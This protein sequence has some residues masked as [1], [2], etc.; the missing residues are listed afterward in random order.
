M[1]NFQELQEFSHKNANTFSYG[2]RIL[3]AKQL[4]ETIEF[5]YSPVSRM[6]GTFKE[7][8]FNVAKLCQEKANL[9]NRTPAVMLSGGMDSHVV[10]SSFVEQGLECVPVMSLIKLNGRNL[11]EH[12]QFYAEK[13]CNYF[14]LK[15]EK[16]DVNLEW[17]SSNEA[18]SIYSNVGAFGI[19]RLV[20][21]KADTFAWN[22]LNGMAVYGNGD[23]V[24][25]NK[26]QTWCLRQL[27]QYQV[28]FKCG[29]L[30]NKVNVSI[31]F[32]HTPEILASFLNEGIIKMVTKLKS[33]EE[34]TEFRFV[35]Y[36]VYRKHWP[37]LEMRPKFS[38]MEKCKIFFDKAREDF[39]SRLN[40]IYD[41]FW[42]KP[43][44]Q[45]NKIL[46]P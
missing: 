41:D 29:L 34:F 13:I 39:C 37:F 27:G 42:Y 33:P 11:S 32:Q 40:V 38:G 15:L 5:H 26:L 45:I 4:G 7:E 25:D 23:I 21:N 31:F 20:H 30:E 8:C 24:I 19:M 1:Y 9:M 10:L 16:T 28:P 17:I 35:K 6:V 12:E 43:I 44:D 3:G 22:E 14:G 2:G 46:I 36:Q 18:F